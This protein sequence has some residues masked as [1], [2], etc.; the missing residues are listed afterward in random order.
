MPKNLGYCY[1]NNQKLLAEQFYFYS[2]N[3]KRLLSACRSNR[4]V[5]VYSAEDAITLAGSS[6]REDESVRGSIDD[7]YRHHSWRWQAQSPGHDKVEALNQ[8]EVARN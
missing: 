5:S 3:N 7:T 6:T 4:P 2:P 1:L 8:A